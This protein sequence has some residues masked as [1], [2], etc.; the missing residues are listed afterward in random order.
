MEL[1]IPLS[2]RNGPL[3][4]QIY[5]SL[6]QAILSGTLRPGERLPSTRE[7]AEKLHVSRTVVLLAYDQ[8][9]AEGFLTGR[10]GSGTFIAEGLSLRQRKES[11]RPAKLRLSNFGRYAAETVSPIA[12]S[13]RRAQSLR[14]DFAYGQTDTDIFP[15]AAWRRTL[16]RNERRTVLRDL[17]YGPATGN[18]NLQEAIAA[19]VRKSRAVACD[20]SQV[21]IVNGAQQA[22]DL[23]VRVLLARGDRVAI[24][25]PQYR[26]ARH[27]LLAAEARLCPVP[28]DNDGIVTGKLPDRARAAFV[29]PSHQLPTGA[30]LT[31]SRRLELLAWA[32][33]Q[34]AVIV[35][36]DYDG[37]FRYEGQ[38]LESLQGLDPEGRVIYIGTFS[39]TIFPSLRIGY[40]I[41]PKSLVPAIS[42]AKWLCDRHTGT[43]EQRTL[44]EFISSGMYER[45]LHQVRKRNTLR[46]TALLDAIAKYIGNGAE[47]TGEGA[48]A[49]IVLWPNRRLDEEI[50][51]R[52][53]AA[54]NVGIYGIAPYFLRTPSRAGFMIGYS[55]MKEADIREGIK[56]LGNVL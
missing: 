8:L 51:I 17:D 45:H 25:D 42:A 19:H 21:I 38:P 33:R 44:A 14:Y 47:I 37:E 54:Q 10:H 13:G 50:I 7:M 34:N 16:L 11:T 4:R 26:G 15:F 2:E 3:Y 39:R 1:L 23:I 40:L 43:L 53:A 49:H 6:R 46:R 28:V 18:Q 48:G 36:D 35:E 12:H 24:E 30:V 31:L 41:A 55:R 29:T 22:I 32:R 9:L 52:K 56:R 5:L 20:P 27:A